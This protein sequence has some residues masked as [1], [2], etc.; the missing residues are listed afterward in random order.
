MTPTSSANRTSA[1]GDP[2]AA[3]RRARRIAFAFSLVLLS[4]PWRAAPARADQPFKPSPIGYWA[5]EQNQGVVQIY[6]CGWQTLCGA[7]VGIEF[8][9][10]TDPMPMTWN[11]RSQCRFVLI[12]NLKPRG[13]AWV[14]AITNPK[15]GHSYGARVS[16]ASPGVLKVRG[17]LL[18]A[19][20][21]QTQ[22]WT[23]YPGTP[24]ANCRMSA[25]DFK[26]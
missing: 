8:D 9:R 5:L 2:G 14:G 18:F 3:A 21:G 19:A 10:P 23:R 4:M 15:S 6:T 16:L 24:P 22:T 11:H 13:D 7:L 26:R 1:R 25:A 17:Y 20:L 12:S